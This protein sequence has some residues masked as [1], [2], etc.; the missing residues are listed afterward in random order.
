MDPKITNQP[1]SI[2]GIQQN[3][4]DAT[5]QLGRALSQRKQTNPFADSRRVQG[6]DIK[7]KETMNSKI[8][9]KSGKQI[10]DVQ[11]NTPAVANPFGR[12]FTSRS[13]KDPFKDNQVD[14]VQQFKESKEQD[15][16]IDAEK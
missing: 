6:Q 3:T 14:L 13:Q 5:K 10:S 4:L 9:N 12:S 7:E 11:Q 16:G 1:E 15:E 8:T 2:Q